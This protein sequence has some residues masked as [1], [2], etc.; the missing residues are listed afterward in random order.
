MAR[1]AGSG[2]MRASLA[3]ALGALAAL[4][5]LYPG[6]LREP[7]FS[8][9]Y[10]LLDKVR[11]ASFASLFSARALAYGYWRPWS[12]ELHFAILERAFGARP[13][14]FHLVSLALAAATI[15]LYFTLARRML[16]AR[17]AVLAGCGLAALAA[18]ELPVRWAAAAQDLWMLAF[19]LA[20]LNALALGRTAAACIALALGLLSKETAAVLPAIAF[21]HEIMLQ[22]L[23]PARAARRVTPLVIVTLAWLAVHPAFGGRWW[24]ARGVS[25]PVAA[26]QS[27]AIAMV[28][29]LLASLNLDA[30]LRPRFGWP[31]ALALGLP[32]ALLPAACAAWA[33]RRIPSPRGRPPADAIDS[34]RLPTPVEDHALAGEIGLTHVP[35]AAEGHILT[36][37]AWRVAGFGLLWAAIAWLPL[38]LPFLIW[39]PYYALFGGMGLWIAIAAGLDRRPAI[40]VAAIVSLALL[41]V[42]RIETPV[43]NGETRSCKPRDAASWRGPKRSCGCATRSCRAA[44]ACSSPASRAGWCSSPAP[45]TLRRCGYGSTA[46]CTEASGRTIARAR[47]RRAAARTTSSPTIRRAAGERSS[48]VREA[49]AGR[50]AA[51]TSGAP[52]TN[53]SR[54]PSRRRRILPW[55]RPSTR[56]SR[57]PIRGAP[58]MPTSPP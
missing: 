20:S 11:G 46:R 9:D 53:G 49:A 45:A 28:R 25:L 32:G 31:R 35:A 14:P 16:G 39:Q 58:T 29:S 48:R 43:W 37:S 50:G 56:R 52:I 40:S 21:V 13:L 27:P 1:A 5:V 34:A 57:A 8:D 38:A 18:W 42:A 36:G 4:L 17:G 55:P 30:P 33:A 2:A 15:L 10:I 6:S 7:F 26:Y 44:R 41:R 3:V 23:S 24:W 19:A 54:S 22:G 12:R 47:R 51:T